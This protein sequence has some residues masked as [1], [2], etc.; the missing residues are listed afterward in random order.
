MHARRTSR[1]CQEG[2]RSRGTVPDGGLG[3]EER[4]SYATVSARGR[5]SCRAAPLA[6]SLGP[7][8]ECRHFR[9]IF[10]AADFSEKAASHRHFARRGSHSQEPYGVGMSSNVAMTT[11]SACHGVDPA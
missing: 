7:A 3:S 8:P 9:S 1:P 11:L 6:V 10:A 4:Q 2:R 5:A